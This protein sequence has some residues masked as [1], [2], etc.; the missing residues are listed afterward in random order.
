MASFL[1]HGSP[2]RAAEDRGRP[3]NHL[4]QDPEGLR[5]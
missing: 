5:S 1:T 2:R 3:L 4:I